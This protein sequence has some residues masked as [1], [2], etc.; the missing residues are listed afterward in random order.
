MLPNIQP[1]ILFRERGKKLLTIGKN[2][3]DEFG[4]M[5][6]ECGES[7]FLS[8]CY[9]PSIENQ[10]N[11]VIYNI[12]LNHILK[13]WDKSKTQLHPSSISV[14]PEEHISIQVCCIILK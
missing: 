5:I 10:S 3:L 7:D 1:S 11:E 4:L 2:S 12:V 9:G 14:T 8:S 13:R 6:V